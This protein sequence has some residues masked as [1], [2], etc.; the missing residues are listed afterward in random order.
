MLTFPEIEIPG[1]EAERPANTFNKD[2]LPAP[3]APM[4][5]QSPLEVT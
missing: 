1:A 2:D 4:M 5:A 3:E